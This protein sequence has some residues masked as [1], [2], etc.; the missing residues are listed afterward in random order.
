M[1][2]LTHIRADFV[3]Y[4]PDT[5]APGVLYVSRRFATASHLCCCGCGHEVVTPLNAA[6]WRLREHAGSVSLAPSIGNWSLSCRSHYWI[7]HGRVR[8]ASAFDARQIAAVQMRDCH[9]AIALRPVRHGLSARIFGAL[10]AAGKR[11]RSWFGR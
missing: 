6:K 2:R 7:D 9:D 10:A 5:L 1:S 4:L 8:W 3:E 11:L